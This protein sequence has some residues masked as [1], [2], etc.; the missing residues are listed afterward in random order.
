MT[1]IVTLL[2]D[3]G[4]RD[5]FASVMKGVMM[6]INPNI[7]IIDISHDVAKYDVEAAAYTLLCAYK[8]FPEGT[9]HVVVVD[10]GVGTKRR[11]L[12]VKSRNYLFVGPDNGVLIP[13]ARRDGLEKVFEIKNEKL[14]L[15]KISTTFHGRDIFAPVAAW[16]SKG[17]PLDTVGPPLSKYEELALL[18]PC[19]IIGRTIECN[20]IH[21]DGFGNVVFNIEPQDVNKVGLRHGDHVEVIFPTTTV[22][23]RL[24]PSYGYVKSGEPVLVINSEEFLELAIREGNAARKYGIRRGD[25]AFIKL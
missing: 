12:V 8:W 19:K 23:A 6:S 22:K 15:G 5:H 14:T 10:P 20:V 17:A 9:I 3:F 25:P 16:L 1:G 24:Q 13:A 18:K 4:T 11:G 21:I 7:R 2:T